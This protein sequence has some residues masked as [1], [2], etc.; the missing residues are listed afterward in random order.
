MRRRKSP[1]VDPNPRTKDRDPADND[2]RCESVLWRTRQKLCHAQDRD[3][4][5]HLR[6]VRRDPE[7]PGNAVRRLSA[8]LSGPEPDRHGPAE[9]R[10]HLGVLLSLISDVAAIATAAFGTIDMALLD[11][12]GKLANM[13]LY[14]LFGGKSLGGAM[15]YAHATGS[16]LED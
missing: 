14:Q 16:D 7:Q 6:P 15:V 8:R 1:N 5:G 13:P 3:S 11:I 10:G 12:K 9:Q 2:C 4:S